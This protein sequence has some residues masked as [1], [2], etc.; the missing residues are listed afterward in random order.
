[1]HARTKRID[2]A[3]KAA[4]ERDDYKCRI[5]GL[6]LEH[7]YCVDGAHVLPRNV[8][9]PLYHADSPEWIVTMCARHHIQYDANHNPKQKAAWLKDHGLYIAAN[10]ILEA[11]GEKVS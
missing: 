7:G 6:G 1:M 10:K 9:F 2:A 5:C 4:K 8:P 11:I 3:I